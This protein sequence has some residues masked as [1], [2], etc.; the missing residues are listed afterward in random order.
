MTLNMKQSYS[1]LWRHAEKIRIRN[2]EK[3]PDQNNTAPTSAVRVFKTQRRNIN[4]NSQE[5]L[6]NI[7]TYVNGKKNWS[8]FRRNELTGADVFFIFQINNKTIIDIRFSQDIW[9]W[10]SPQ[11]V[12]STS[13]FGI[14]WEHKTFG[15]IS[16]SSY[17]AQPHSIIVLTI[18]II[19]IKIILNDKI[20]ST[21]KISSSLTY[22]LYCNVHSCYIYLP[23]YPIMYDV[24]SLE[25]LVWFKLPSTFCFLSL[26]ILLHVTL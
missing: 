21:H 16:P 9:K 11:F 3:T 24:W 2:V 15:L 6:W 10:S 22:P 26:E 12:L 4:K 19:I 13:A 8:L 17:H 23:R 18:K 20:K 25:S 14:N 7:L 1:K 5:R